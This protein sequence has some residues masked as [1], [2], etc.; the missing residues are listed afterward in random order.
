MQPVS[1]NILAVERRLTSC[2]LAFEW[3]VYGRVATTSA[4]T[5]VFEQRLFSYK[6]TLAFQTAQWLLCLVSCASAYVVSVTLLDKVSL[7]LQ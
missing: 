7:S 4:F 3:H 5:S 6:H 2:L 1:S